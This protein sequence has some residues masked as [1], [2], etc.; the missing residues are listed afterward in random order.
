MMAGIMMSMAATV[1]LAM[2]VAL[3]VRI[4]IAVPRNVVTG[5]PMSMADLNR[6]GHRN[7]SRRVS[8]RGAHTEIAGPPGVAL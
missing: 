2:L 6:D 3:P 5:C 8:I 1:L 7:V 4:L